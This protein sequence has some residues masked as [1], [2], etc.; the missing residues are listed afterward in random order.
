[1]I[2]IIPNQGEETFMLRHIKVYIILNWIIIKGIFKHR[3]N[4]KTAI[5]IKYKK[6]RWVYLRLK[7]SGKA[8]KPEN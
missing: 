8:S 6:L 7:K 5:L 2:L 3:K 4:N 1:M